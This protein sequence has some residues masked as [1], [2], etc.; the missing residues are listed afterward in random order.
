VEIKSEPGFTERPVTYLDIECRG[1]GHAFQYTLET[2]DKLIVDDTLLAFTNQ[3]ARFVFH[4]VNILWY[5]VRN[6]VVRTAIKPAP[7]SPS[8]DM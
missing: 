8:T 6:G 7:P 1:I 3:K 4:R 2:T 5:S